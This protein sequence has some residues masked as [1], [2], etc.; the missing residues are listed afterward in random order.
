MLGAMSISLRQLSYLA[1]EIVLKEFVPNVAC[2]YKHV[3]R[4]ES[5]ARYAERVMPSYTPEQNH[6]KQCLLR[7][8]VVVRLYTRQC[9]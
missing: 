4:L 8:I 9:S 5:I 2:A 3:Y 6:W 7:V 1:S